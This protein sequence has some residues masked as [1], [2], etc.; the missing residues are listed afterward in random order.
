MS[1]S[2]A[3]AR[4]PNICARIYEQSHS[5]ERDWLYAAYKMRDLCAI[6]AQNALPAAAVPMHTMAN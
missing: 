4:A 3:H 6:C 2:V 5:T 1:V